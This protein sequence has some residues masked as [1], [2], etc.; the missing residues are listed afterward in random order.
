MYCTQ[1]RLHT[2]RHPFGWCIF[3][4]LINLL[5]LVHLFSCLVLYIIIHPQ[6]IADTDKLEC[7]DQTQ[8]F[9]YIHQGSNPPFQF[10]PHHFLTLSPPFSSYSSRDT[11]TV[12]NS[13]VMLNVAIPFQASS[14]ASAAR[15]ISIGISGG[16]IGR[17]VAWRRGMSPGSWEGDPV[18]NT[19]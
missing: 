10:P 16:R 19:F 9:T 1:F 13:C 12:M 6:W 14:A 11:P 2:S 17:I 15:M 3:H 4:V 18:R 5:S 8:V 7:Q